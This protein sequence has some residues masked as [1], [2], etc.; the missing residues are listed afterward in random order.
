MLQ[1]AIEFSNCRSVNHGRAT[2]E[3]AGSRG[4]RGLNDCG[5][6]HASDLHRRNDGI[7]EKEGEKRCVTTSS[8]LPT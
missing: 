4:F 2:A 7:T 8:C 5:L 6:G 1:V 3:K